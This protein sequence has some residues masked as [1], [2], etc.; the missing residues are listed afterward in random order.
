[1]IPAIRQQTI[2]DLLQNQ[3]ILYLEDLLNE[4]NISVSTLRR[5][6]RELERH[7]GRG[8]L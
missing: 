4:L 6:L 7:R 5:D 1:M 2:L 3:D 8:D